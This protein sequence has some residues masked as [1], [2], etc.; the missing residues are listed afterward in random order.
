MKK[1]ISKE[2]MEHISNFLKCT[3]D[4]LQVIG[5]NF[6]VKQICTDAIHIKLLALPSCVSANQANH[7]VPIY[8]KFTK[9]MCDVVNDMRHLVSHT[10]SDLATCSR[11]VYLA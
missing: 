6:L 3:D 4:L 8:M 5:F 7:E 2:A 1:K 10:G 11:I 9:A